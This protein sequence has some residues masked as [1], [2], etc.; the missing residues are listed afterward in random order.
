MNLQTVKI[1]PLRCV[2][3]PVTLSSVNPGTP[4]PDIFTHGNR[5][6]VDQINGIRVQIFPYFRKENGYCIKKVSY[7]AEAAEEAAAET[8]FAYHIRNVTWRTEHGTGFS[9]VP[10]E[11]HH[12]R[13]SRCYYFRIRHPALRV[14]IMIKTSQ[15][16]LCEAV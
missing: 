6:G 4:D 3:S 1:S 15:N 5:E 13:D 9:E 2:E 16:I 12:G 8:A 7:P 14:F 10:P 11:K